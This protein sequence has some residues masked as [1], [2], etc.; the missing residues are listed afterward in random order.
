M[1]KTERIGGAAAVAIA[2]A[3]SLSISA[4]T[5]SPYPSFQQFLANR[6]DPA[7]NAIC[8]SIAEHS[9]EMVSP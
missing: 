7:V 8:S 3:L 6:I 4:R 2:A 9:E 1:T 5:A